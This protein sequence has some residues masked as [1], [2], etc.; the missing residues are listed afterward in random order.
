MRSRELTSIESANLKAIETAVGEYAFLFPSRTGLEKSILDATEPL[1]ALLRTAKVHD[2]S[3]QCH[4]K[5]YRVVLSGQVV[6]NDGSHVVP[7]SLYRP[8]TKE[9]DPR[10]WPSQL[11]QYAAAEDVVATAVVDKTITLF[12][13]TRLTIANDLQTKIDTGATRWLDRLL[14]SSRSSSSYNQW[15]AELVRHFF[16]PQSAGERVRLMVT[17]D[18]LDQNFASLGGTNG[19]LAAMLAEQP[20]LSYDDETLFSRGLRLFKIWK[21]PDL[22]PKNYPDTLRNLDDAPLFLPYLCLLSLAWTEGGDSLAANAYYDR[23]SL[24]YPKH[25]LTGQLGSWLQLWQ[26]LEAWTVQ[27]NRRRGNFVVEILGGWAH[28]GIPR[29]QVIFTPAKIER[30]P[31]LFYQCS[32]ESEATLTLDK[33]RGL[34]LAHEGTAAGVLGSMVLQEI[35]EQTPLG[36]SALEVILEHLENWDGELPKNAA[37]GEAAVGA[38]DNGGTLLLALR[39][40]A[41]NTKWTAA[42]ALVRDTRCE[43]LEFPD[44]H[45][46]VSLHSELLATVVDRDGSNVD[47]TALAEKWIDG[48]TLRGTLREIGTDG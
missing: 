41:D 44:K 4:F 26:G 12:N 48:T 46:M 40:V 29:S 9:G 3:A 14:G 36:R 47:A 1:R 27:L 38:S 8:T 25:D 30:F 20:L 18:V 5:E 39:P 17:R 42:L 7:I 6:A 32:L 43:K 35:K 13:L 21:M 45:W 28:V 33:L 22:R 11:G 23:L 15:A 37:A 19:F 34:I 2:F 24:L 16:G 10:I 31:E